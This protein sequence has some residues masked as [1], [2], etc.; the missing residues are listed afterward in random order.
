MEISELKEC[1]FFVRACQL[2]EIKTLV[3]NFFK[4]YLM[5]FFPSSLIDV[6]HFLFDFIY[7]KSSFYFIFDENFIFLTS[8][9]NIF[10]M[11]VYPTSD[12]KFTN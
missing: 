1:A 12:Q 7:S 5:F 11:H 4:Y 2:P 10:F 3:S 6:I 9:N 8:K